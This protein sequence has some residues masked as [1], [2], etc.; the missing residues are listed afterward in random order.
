MCGAVAGLG[1]KAPGTFGRNF[2]IFKELKVFFISVFPPCSIVKSALM[3]CTFLQYYHLQLWLF[4][5]GFLWEN[6]PWWKL[7]F[8]S[9]PASYNSFTWTLFIPTWP[10]STSSTRVPSGQLKAIL[11]NVGAHLLRHGA[12]WMNMTA[13]WYVVSVHRSAV[14]F[15]RTRQCVSILTGLTEQ[16]GYLGS[17]LLG[18]SCAWCQ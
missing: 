4:L 2:W 5:G 3:S 10:T 18:G 14:C 8:W 17:V 13:W 1:L 15:R 12:D 6:F 9:F 16:S 7:L 11:G